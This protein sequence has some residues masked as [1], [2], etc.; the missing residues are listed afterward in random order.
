MTEV[1]LEK[2]EEAGL[3]EYESRAYICLLKYGSMEGTQVAEKTKIPKTRVYDVLRSINEKGL[4]SKIQDRPMKFRP[5]DPGKGLKA[6]YER[7]QKRLQHIEEK[8][9]NSL[10]N[11]DRIGKRDSVEE[12]VE[13]VKGQKNM[14][15]NLTERMDDIDEFAKGIVIG[16]KPPKK[17]Q[18]KLKEVLERGVE[19]KI[20]IS[21]FNREN[22]E[23]YEKLDEAAR[24]RYYDAEPEFALL[25]IDGETVMINVLDPEVE[26]ERLSIFFEVEALAKAMDE[27]LESVWNKSVPI[28][29]IDPADMN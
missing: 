20:I 12:R 7:K 9:L 29:D 21:E 8:A 17:S 6:L 22:Q 26:E 1:D 19:M 15:S 27:Y 13:V 2:L 28:E 24:V 25:V 16:R 10:E 18:L 4:A 5:I 23:A 11:I 14:F 3:T